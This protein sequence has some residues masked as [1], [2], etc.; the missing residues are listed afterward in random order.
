M[1]RYYGIQYLRGFAALLVVIYHSMMMSAVAPYFSNPVGEF[2]VDIFFVISGFVMWV[3]TERNEGSPIRFML[4]RV[5]RVAPLYWLVTLAIVA[6]SVLLPSL[7]FQSRGIDPYYIIKSLL[8]I[9]AR[10][11]DIGD[12]TPFYTIGWTLVYEMFFYFLFGLCL[13]IRKPNARIA[14]FSALILTLILIGKLWPNGDPIFFTYTNPVMLEF[15]AGVLLGLHRK[16][17]CN[18]GLTQ[19]LAIMTASVVALFVAESDQASRALYFGVPALLLVLSAVSLEHRIR[20][21]PMRTPNLLGEISYSLY[22]SHPISQRIWYAFFVYLFGPILNASDAVQYAAGAIIAGLIGGAACYYV[23]ERPL[24]KIA[25]SILHARFST[26]RDT[27]LQ[28]S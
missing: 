14:L 23:F 2:G 27:G 3:S 10:N 20:T 17:L 26:N 1:E 22:L 11:P 19:S 25:T 16:K 5:A 15:L 8:F 28:E 4:A 13:F 12:I 24:T 7:F 6:A 21:C 18:L 9:P